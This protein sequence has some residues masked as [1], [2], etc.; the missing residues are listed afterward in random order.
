MNAQFLLIIQKINIIVNGDSI[1]V[2]SLQNFEQIVEIFAY[3]R[4]II[5]FWLLQLGI[6]DCHIIVLLT[7]KLKKLLY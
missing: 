5:G 3:S 7:E 4:I 1:L 2:I 6:K